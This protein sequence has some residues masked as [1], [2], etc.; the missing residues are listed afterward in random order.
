MNWERVVRSNRRDETPA[1]APFFSHFHSTNLTNAGFRP[2]S[3]LTT[4]FPFAP[5]F[6]P[7]GASS[8]L[9]EGLN[10][11]RR[12]VG[13][14]HVRSDGLSA[15]VSFWMFLTDAKASPPKA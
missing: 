10:G 8:E 3:N 4:S 5:G 13:L 2:S 11:P 12:I 6:K 7:A 9:V 15:N 1:S 14:A